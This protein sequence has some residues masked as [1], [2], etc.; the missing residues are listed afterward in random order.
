MYV[1]PH[2]SVSYTSVMQPNL[3]M[4]NKNHAMSCQVLLQVLQTL[5]TSCMHHVT[6][7]REASQIHCCSLDTFLLD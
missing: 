1:M 2:H 4:H 5:M 6:H 7:E 3:F